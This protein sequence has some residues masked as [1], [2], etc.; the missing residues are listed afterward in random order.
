MTDKQSRVKMPGSGRGRYKTLVG[1]SR[2]EVKCPV[3]RCSTTMRQDV[4]KTR[5]LLKLIVWREDNPFVPAEKS[6]ELY[7]S[8]SEVAKLH[9]DYWREHKLTKTTFPAFKRVIKENISSISSYFSNNNNNQNNSPEDETSQVPDLPEAVVEIPNSDEDDVQEGDIVPDMETPRVHIHPPRSE[10][11]RDI[12]NEDDVVEDDFVLD[13]ETPLVQITPP[14]SEGNRDVPVQGDIEST[15]RRLFSTD[16]EDNLSKGIAKEVIKELKSEEEEKAR[17]QARK[18]SLNECIK[19]TELEYF[20]AP[21]VE[22]K[23]HHSIPI[24]LKT[25]VRGDFGVFKKSNRVCKHNVEKHCLHPL[26]DVCVSIMKIKEKSKKKVQQDSR[27]A[28]DILVTNAVFALKE[29][30]D[31]WEWERKI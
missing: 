17:L 13:M 22:N 25:H 28:C 9:T 24:R 7:K 16:E 2:E 14:R 29:L 4:M 1:S 26:H 23:T 20:C 10:V 21:C 30:G 27:K 18:E 12:H 15:V 11:N 31:A 6:D 19:E 8:S 5:H 3:P